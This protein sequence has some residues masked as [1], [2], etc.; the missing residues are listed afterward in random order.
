MEYAVPVGL[1][2]SAEA[3]TLT[4]RA[5]PSHPQFLSIALDLFLKVKLCGPPSSLLL[6]VGQY[7]AGHSQLYDSGT[8]LAT[9][10]EI[11]S[12]AN[13]KTRSGNAKGIK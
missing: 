8:T 11:L 2:L 9:I 3:E 6:N 4:Q 5:H 1:L 7:K 12:Y 13:R 10:S